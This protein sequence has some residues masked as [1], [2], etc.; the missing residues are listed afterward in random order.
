MTCPLA[1]VGSRRTL[2]SPPLVRCRTRLELACSESP[3]A[4]SCHHGVTT[5]DG[6]LWC[7]RCND[8]SKRRQEKCSFP[9]VYSA[10]KGESV[11]QQWVGKKA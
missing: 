3:I 8:F 2:V 10:F 7:R 4:P 5:K 11:I 9:G 6:V 1:G